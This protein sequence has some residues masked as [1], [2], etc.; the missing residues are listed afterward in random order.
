[1]PVKNYASSTPMEWSTKQNE[2]PARTES[3][4]LNFTTIMIL[5]WNSPNC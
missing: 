4:T 3:G 5:F 2:V 1:M